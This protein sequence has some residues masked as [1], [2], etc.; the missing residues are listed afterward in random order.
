M[1]KIKSIEECP[2]F[3]VIDGVEF[4]HCPSWPGYA[5]DTSGNIWSCVHRKWTWKQRMPTLGR[6]GYWELRVTDTKTGK[7]FLRRV[8]TLVCEA[9][10]GPKPDGLECC[11]NDGSRNNNVPSNLRWDTRGSN[12]Q[13]AIQM[14]TF[15]G[16][17]QRGECHGHTKLTND[18]VRD[19]RRIGG[20]MLL[21]EIAAMFNTSVPH[22]SGILRGERRVH[23]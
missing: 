17:S 15:H 13:D 1:V 12:Q 8:H 18:A 2:P 20:S 7:L 16:N 21:R 11:H 19:I 10:H 23:D 14:G 4:R 3:P 6:L 9:F 22:V 5:A